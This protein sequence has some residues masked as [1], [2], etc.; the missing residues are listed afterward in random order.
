MKKPGMTDPP[1]KKRINTPRE[2]V[3][4]LTGD[5]QAA[6]A[7]AEYRM[8]TRMLGEAEITARRGDTPSST[9]H[10]AY[11]SMHHCARAVLLVLGGVDKWG[12][13]P[14]SHEH[15]IE[16]FAK[17]AQ[18]H[19][20]DVAALG[21]VLIAARAR[22]NIADYDTIQELDA[23]VAVELTWDARAFVDLCARTWKLQAT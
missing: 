1:K 14:K 4:R 21:P 17:Q 9:V 16:H 2:V 22:R 10:A 8:A 18:R 11:Y 19:G 7:R 6:K 5:Q 12:D 13:V 3:V 23:A 20:Q 15:V